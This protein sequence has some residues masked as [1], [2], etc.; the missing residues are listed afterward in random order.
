MAA[1]LT[2]GGL[3][4][5]IKDGTVAGEP[6]WREPSDVLLHFDPRHELVIPPREEVPQF[7]GFG[8]PGER[9]WVDK[10]FEVKEG[11]LWPGW[12]TMEI[13][14][15]DVSGPVKVTFP[16]IEGPGRLVLGRFEDDPERGIR[17][18]VT[19][20]S[21]RADP[22]SVEFP[23][24]SHSHPLWIFNASGIYRITMEMSA[25][26]RSGAKVTDRETLA[27]AVGDV[28]PSMVVPGDGSTGPTPTPTSSSP[29]PS[30][31]G[32]PPVGPTTTAP[33]TP[34]AP[35][36][37]T[38]GIPP[39]ATASAP[40]P[41][42]RAPAPTPG[43]SRFYLGV[44]P[45]AGRPVR[46]AVWPLRAPE[47]SAVLGGPGVGSGALGT[48]VSDTETLTF[49]VGA[50]DPHTVPEGTSAGGGSTGGTSTDGAST[51]GAEPG[52]T[53]GSGTTGG[54]VSAGTAGGAAA[55]SADRGTMASTGAGSALLLGGTAATLAAVGAGFRYVTRR[56]AA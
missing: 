25:T 12:N 6:V 44:G 28:D 20:D 48:K 49:A 55:G 8:E 35:P 13:L 22:G 10:D 41:D 1:R 14:P 36:T 2:D 32:T 37:H 21:A 5:R 50:T 47:P 53:G 27:V 54:N 42:P 16:K 11:L 23:A 39:S 52:G 9:L 31:T 34:S 46:P 18:G 29:S 19:V 38:A 17:I 26:L 51:G 3:E 30:P 56:S 43:H 24:Y 15:S 40:P 45:V 33:T 7:Q 4:Y